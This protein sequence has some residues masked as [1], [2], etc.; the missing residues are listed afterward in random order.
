[1]NGKRVSGFVL[2]FGVLVIV[3]VLGVRMLKAPAELS[4]GSGAHEHGVGHLN[5]AVEGSD[6][7]LEFI[8]PSANML[9][10]E[11]PP[12]TEEQK[13]A[14]DGAV[15][16]LRDGESLIVPP[17]GAQCRIADSTVD[18]DIDSHSGSES[19]GADPHEHDE[20]DEPQ[21]HSE[22]TAEY[23]FICERPEELSG[24]DVML[25]RGF[26]GLQL[27]EVQLLTG[28]R[29]V[30]LELTGENHWIPF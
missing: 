27:I 28:S 26:P 3:S 24:V 18:T 16:T 21:R 23:H 11:H 10:F 9:G 14:I 7:Y 8:S 13:T 25:F 20:P 1:M 2:S 30:A 29:Q 22:F 17:A 19:E 12:R 4:R 6:L 5:V 15:E